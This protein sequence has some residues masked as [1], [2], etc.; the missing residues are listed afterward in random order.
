MLRR[1]CAIFDQLGGPTGGKGGRDSCVS[2]LTVAGPGGQEV[3]WG[4][5]LKALGMTAEQVLQERRQFQG[6]QGETAQLDVSLHVI[7]VLT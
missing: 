2:L 5:V 6:R 3:A 4:G 1:C 7:A